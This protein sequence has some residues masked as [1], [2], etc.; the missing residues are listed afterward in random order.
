MIDGIPCIPFAS[1]KILRMR[2]NS[3]TV[4]SW[5]AGEVGAVTEKMI[6][7]MVIL[8]TTIVA[9]TTAARDLVQL[10]PAAFSCIQ[11]PCLPFWLP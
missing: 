9:M 10:L 6:A 5:Q 11:L 2:S 7:D 3:G 8:V 4:C 1:C